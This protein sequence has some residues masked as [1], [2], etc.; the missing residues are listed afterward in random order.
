MSTF[1]SLPVELVADILGELD[2]ATLITV[3]SLSRRLRAIAS[4]SSLNPWRRPILRT[5]CNSNG[6][7]EYEPKL[8]HL[9][10]RHTVPRQNW[11]EILTLGKA[12]YI[13][14]EMTLPNLKETEW[15]ECF[16][17]RFL[18]GWIKWKTS[19]WKAAYLKILHRVWHRSHS[20]CTAD[21]AWT[22]YILLNRNGSANLLDASSRNHS[23]M[24][25]FHE[26]KL[27]NNV[28]HLPTH[29]RLVVEFRD[30]RIIALGVLSK[31]RSYF[32]INQNARLL[33]H[34][35]GM[36]KGDD[37]V[38]SA[39]A[40]HVSE[41]SDESFPPVLETPLPIRVA[42]PINVKDV[43]RPLTHP[44]PSPC[45]ANYPFYTFGGEDKRWLGNE[46]MEEGGRQWIGPMMLTAQLINLQTKQ[47]LEDGP[48]LQDLDLV[49]GPGRTQFSSLSWAD[50]T[51]IA[52]WLEL[53]AKINGQGLGH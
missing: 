37:E 28:A 47:H 30:V 4:D 21:E 10:V 46:E 27:Q 23:P 2:I 32:S 38:A 9:S 44:L 24:N 42:H 1:E 48:P 16:R 11:V 35:P 15:E 36:T 51:A 3:S 29:V 19:T 52:P 22:K 14:Y 17:R 33:L 8:R 41:G 26:I 13:L 7:G 45:H 34:P 5:M 43:Y 50:L 12:E 18:P 40:G 39:Q 6:D 49:V 25:T 20:S 31:P 53:T